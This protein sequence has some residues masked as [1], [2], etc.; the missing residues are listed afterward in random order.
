MLRRYRRGLDCRKPLKITS[1]DSAVIHSMNFLIRAD[2]SVAMGTGHVMRCLAL[3]Q[4]WQDA[5]GR[6][7]FAAAEITPAMQHRLVAEGCHVVDLSC[8]AGS[9]DDAKQT[10]AL[11]QECQAAWIVVDGYQFKSEYQRVIKDAGSKLLF[12]D[13]YGH[14]KRYCA[15]LILNQNLDANENLYSAR[16]PYTRLLLGTK[17]CLLRREFAALREWKR[18]IAPVAR[19]VLVMMGGSDPENVTARAIAALQLAKIEGIEA[20]VVVGGSN[21]H[22]SEL[23]SL[24]SCCEFPLQLHRDASNIAE[25]MCYADMAIS[26]AGST[27]WELAFLGLPAL[28]LDLAENQTLLARQLHKRNCAVHIGN[29]QIVSQDLV[30]ALRTLAGSQQLRKTLSAESRL[31]VDGE[32]AGRIL[33]ALGGKPQ[34]SLRPLTAEDRELLW[35]WVN[36]PQVR[37]ASFSSAPV[38]WEIHNAWFDKKNA[39]PTTEIFIAEDEQGTPIGQIRFDLRSDRDWEVDV[40]LAQPMRGH[41]LASEL[42][43]R[44]VDLLRRT[45]PAATVHALIKPS[46]LASVKAFERSGFKRNGTERMPGQDIIHLVRRPD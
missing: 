40:S 36:D 33:C 8:T 39:D 26:A 37:K 6:T 32:G 35:R 9:A 5:G 4:S 12:F 10:S 1:S 15:D 18:E 14:C 25:L 43:G 45:H 2:A 27:C 13:D 44:G 30:H 29:G 24:A 46:N 31:L 28:L 17:Y 19:K 23:Q 21:P 11:A 16:E 41:G 22:F 7:T 42:I 20:A 3:A 34:L 38:S